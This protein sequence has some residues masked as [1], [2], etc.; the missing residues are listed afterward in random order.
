MSIL[1]KPI[2]TKYKPLSKKVMNKIKV[3]YYDDISLILQVRF[4]LKKYG[5][6]NTTT[7]LMNQNDKELKKKIA[8]LVYGSKYKWFRSH[9]EKFN[10]SQNE[11][12]VEQIKHQKLVK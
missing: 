6:A 12:I 5:K 8:K 3:T 11:L 4:L 10:D 2:I 9:C 7:I 1:N